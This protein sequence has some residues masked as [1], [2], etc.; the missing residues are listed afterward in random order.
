[1]FR[2]VPKA[3]TIIIQ[4][5][6]NYAD[7]MELVESIAVNGYLDLEPLFVVEEGGKKV[8]LLQM[9]GSSANVWRARRGSVVM[10]TVNSLHVDPKDWSPSQSR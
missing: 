9:F 7:L 1:M 10:K 6:L 4:N 2:R 3:R 8:V 5:L